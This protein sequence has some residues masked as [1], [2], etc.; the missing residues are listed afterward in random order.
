MTNMPLTKHQ[1]FF[2]ALAIVG[3]IIVF[4][5]LTNISLPS[6]Q[7]PTISAPPQSDITA[8]DTTVRDDL[9]ENFNPTDLVLINHKALG[10]W[11]IALVYSTA[12]DI[13]AGVVVLQKT[14]GSWKLVYGPATDYDPQEL[15][16][17]GMPKEL[18][19]QM[20]DVFIPQ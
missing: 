9:R 5:I 10:D 11:A 15:E 18:I 4:V 14:N 2:A 6:T 20:N 3:A 16:G 12:E 17:M 13:D 8:I 19:D 7:P 1:I